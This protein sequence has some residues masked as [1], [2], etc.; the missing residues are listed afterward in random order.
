[1]YAGH[2]V[3]FAGLAL[4]LG[5]WLGAAVFAFH[6][7]WFDRR[8]KEDE[9][10][11][12]ELFGEAYRAYCRRVKQVGSEDVLTTSWAL[13]CLHNATYRRL[14]VFATLAREFQ[15]LR[16]ACSVLSGTSEVLIC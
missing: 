16:Q 3:F 6:A 8:V 7:A 2:L 1:M 12:A 5:S 13:S 9:A 10:R 14:S 11:L 4:A 15:R